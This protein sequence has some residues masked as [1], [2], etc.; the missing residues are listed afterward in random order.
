MG[1]ISGEGRNQ[2]YWLLETVDDSVREDN[3]GR[4]LDVF[5]D[6]SELRP[7]CFRRPIPAGRWGGYLQKARRPES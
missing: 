1:Y 3:P 5:V 2:I 7:R 4:F 6:K